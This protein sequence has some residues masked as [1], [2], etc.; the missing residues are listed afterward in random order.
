MYLYSQS[1]WY[2]LQSNCLQLSN[3]C[4]LIVFLRIRQWK[5]FQK[6]C[7]SKTKTYLNEMNHC[8]KT[9]VK[10]NSRTA[11]LPN[12]TPYEKMKKIRLQFQTLKSLVLKKGH[13]VTNFFFENCYKSNATLHIPWPYFLPVH[14]VSK[15]WV[16][17]FCPSS[18]YKNS[19]TSAVHEKRFHLRTW[20]TLPFRPV[21]SDTFSGPPS[22]SMSWSRVL[23]GRIFPSSSTFLNISAFISQARSILA[24]GGL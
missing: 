18:N 19:T 4:S 22:S 20:T 12:W 23:A 24:W 7:F 5:S 13:K 3:T 14:S 10:I 9:C 15:P 1:K 2:P 17:F 11:V 21:I 16:I 8:I 6:D